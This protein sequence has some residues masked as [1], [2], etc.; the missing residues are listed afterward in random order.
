MT[1]T[2]SPSPEERAAIVRNAQERM[3]SR[4][5]GWLEDKTV[6]S[7]LT[8]A[9]ARTAP[10]AAEQQAA[11]RPAFLDFEASSL[12]SEKSYPISVGVA[13]LDESLAPDYY[14]LIRPREGWTNWDEKSESIHGIPRETL[15]RDG[16]DADVVLQTLTVLSRTFRFY[17]TSNYDQF[18]MNRLTEGNPGILVHDFQD[19][20]YDTASGDCLAVMDAYERANRETKHTHNALDD[21]RHLRNVVR[22]LVQGEPK[23]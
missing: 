11:L 16:A 10:L 17:V 12:H 7:A 22:Q 1:E 18:W 19:F 13:P 20:M 9:A 15:E 23:P 21:A 3:T 4:A 14:A 2:F 8:A 6:S 5:E